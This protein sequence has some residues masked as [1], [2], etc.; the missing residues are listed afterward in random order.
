MMLL[1][2][3]LRFVADSPGGVPSYLP[4]IMLT[5]TF[6]G[7]NLMMF[8]FD[9]AGVKS[10][11]LLPFRSRDVI[12]AKNLYYLATVAFEGA[13]AFSV[14]LMFSINSAPLL[15]A[16]AL[17]YAALGLVAAALGTWMSITHP[18]QPPQRGMARRNPGGVIGV[19]AL[20][21]VVAAGGVIVGMVA[22]AR[23]L[24]PPSL[25][26]LAG[27]LAGAVCL[28]VAA[29]LWWVSLERNAETF[30]AGREKLIE[31]LARTTAD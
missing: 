29:V 30:E 12:V 28:A 8:G 9:G 19:L 1:F 17:G 10:L 11:V 26:A 20:L 2:V 24:A 7:R 21:C 23:W 27:A 18:V 14:M 13:L 22:L 31:V 5:S 3:G 6:A 4:F 16:F 25:D 15:G